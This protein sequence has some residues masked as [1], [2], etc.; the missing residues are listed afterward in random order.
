MNNL[1]IGSI[2]SILLL[3]VSNNS[4]ICQQQKAKLVENG[5][6]DIGVDYNL[7]I[8]QVVANG[9]YD[10]KNDYINSK[11]FST[12]RKGYIRVKIVIYKATQNIRSEEVIRFL[13]KKKLVSADFYTLCALANERPE[14]PRQDRIIGLGS[15]CTLRNNNRSRYY[16]LLYRSDD[17]NKRR[18][19]LFIP[20][21]GNIWIEGDCFAAVKIIIK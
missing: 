17:S 18:L 8:E 4:V 1:L 3:L 6:Y 12:S 20:S 10:S 19:G 11:N 2:T 16:P 5:S 7:T 21:D 13:R 14:L 15:F 9:N